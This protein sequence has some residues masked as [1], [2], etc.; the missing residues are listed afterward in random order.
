MCIVLVV[1]NNTLCGAGVELKENLCNKSR[2]QIQDF[3]QVVAYTMT[4]HPGAVFGRY[5]DLIWQE[6]G[7][8]RAKSQP[9]YK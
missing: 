1:T 5:L 7:L 3:E 8:C 9:S 4:K 2:E 6:P